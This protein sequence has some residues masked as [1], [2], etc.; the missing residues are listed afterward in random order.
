[1]STYF[2]REAT[3]TDYFVIVSS[4]GAIRFFFFSFFLYFLVK[5]S[6]P[7][8]WICT[9]SI[10]FCLCLARVKMACGRAQ[11]TRVRDDAQ[12]G[13]KVT[14]QPLTS[15]TFLSRSHGELEVSL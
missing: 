7:K 14:S 10:L 9:R 4:L 11:Q 5:M 1:M 3:S 12:S 13:E 6:R 8:L 2:R 15:K